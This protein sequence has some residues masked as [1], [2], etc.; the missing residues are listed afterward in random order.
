MQTTPAG[1]P[2]ADLRQVEAS[3]R[4]ATVA[5]AGI[6]LLSAAATA[7]LLWL[8]YVHH[9]PA[10][11]KNRLLFLPALNASLNG[12]SALALVNGLIFVRSGQVAKHRAAMMTALA[13]SSIFLVSYIINHAVHGDTHYPGHGVLRTIY[14]SILASHVLLSVVA[15]PMVLITFF[16][17]L[18]GRFRQHRA[19]ARYTFPIWL[20]VSVTGVVVY[21]MLHAALH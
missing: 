7:F 20:Y 1:L 16:F 2:P 10:E 19:I 21:A 12:L 8:L 13:F 9:A 11:F 15:L 5:V 14:L 4:P 3:N 17:S 18:S 6:L